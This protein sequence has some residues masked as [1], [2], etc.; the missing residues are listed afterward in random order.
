MT[1]VGQEEREFIRV[2]IPSDLLAS[3]LEWIK[4]HLNPED[5]F[6]QCALDAWAVENGYV[7]EIQH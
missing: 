6:D 4:G 2:V 5:V 1:T 7:K 3:A